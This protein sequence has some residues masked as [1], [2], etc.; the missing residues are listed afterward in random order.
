[1]FYFRW[2]FEHGKIW[3]HLGG[4]LS[5]QTH[6]AYCKYSIA[7]EIILNHPIDM[8]FAVAGLQVYFPYIYIFQLSY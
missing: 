5:G 7:E 4:E 1:M 6:V 8:H 3:Q 2:K